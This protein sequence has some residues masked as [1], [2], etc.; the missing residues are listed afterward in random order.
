VGL[1]RPVGG[2]AVVGAAPAHHRALLADL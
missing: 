2:V 1:V